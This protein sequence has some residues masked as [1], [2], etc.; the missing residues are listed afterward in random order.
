[1]ARGALGF[2][3]DA[4]PAQHV[5]CA[6]KPGH[7]RRGP[8]LHERPRLAGSSRRRDHSRHWGPI[9]HRRARDP[10]CQ[11]PLLVVWHACQRLLPHRLQEAVHAR[12]VGRPLAHVPKPTRLGLQPGQRGTPVEPCEVTLAKAHVPAVGGEPQ[13]GLVVQRLGLRRRA[14]PQFEGLPH[15]VG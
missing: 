11:R 1:M 2:P 4:F 13:R 10:G 6:E 7:I 14:V 5:A 12:A 15:D 9:R 8:M 3:P